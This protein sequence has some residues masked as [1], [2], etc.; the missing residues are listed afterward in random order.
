[1]PPPLMLNVWVSLPPGAITWVKTGY[2]RAA[3]VADAPLVRAT[4]SAPSPS[5]AL[6]ARPA[7]TE[8][9]PWVKLS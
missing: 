4:P 3:V 6:T 7:S 2:S 1:M 8:P 9:E 5:A